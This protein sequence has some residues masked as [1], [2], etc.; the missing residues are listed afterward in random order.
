MTKVILAGVTG[1]VGGEVLRQCIAHPDITTIVA[2]ARRDL[3]DEILKNEK[4]KFV[5]IEDFGVYPEE[6]LKE[7]EGASAAIWTIGT[8]PAKVTSIEA[9]RKTDQTNVLIGANAYLSNSHLPAGEKFRFILCSG[10]GAEHDQGKKLW[11]LEDLRKMRGE[12][13]GLL[14]KLAEENSDN[15]E[16]IVGRP[17]G[18][19]AK[20]N[21]LTRNVLWTLAIGVDSVAASFIH[22]ALHG[23]KQIMENDELRKDGMKALKN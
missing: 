9:L 2:L 3:P 14:I 7:F 8:V 20:E 23:N 17:A 22:S 10:W 12:T 6:S 5:K 16:V 13:E 1:F 11:F 21:F 4:V 19:L 18:I 15:L